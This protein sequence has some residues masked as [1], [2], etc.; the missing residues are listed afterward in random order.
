MEFSLPK[1]T[2]GAL[3]FFFGKS[4]PLD[5]CPIPAYL[6]EMWC[7]WWLEV[8]DLVSIWKYFNI[9]K[10]ENNFNLNIFKDAPP[11]CPPSIYRI[12]AECWNP[13]PEARPTFSIL[14]E[15][16]TACT[17][18]PEIMNSP[19]PSF[20]RPQSMERDATIMRPSGNDDFC[21]QVPNSSDYLIPLPDSRAIAE[22][23]LSEATCVTLP[24]T[25]TTHTLTNSHKLSD[26]CWETSFTKP[27]MKLMTAQQDSMEV[28]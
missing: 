4:F 3:A 28:Q 15:R 24:D 7:N 23:L 9:F 25:L 1:P 6:I 10:F 11:G 5:W 19:L 2:Y 21:L 18:D 8:V 14:L 16:L 12:M 22:R 17:Q 27:A 20:F 26:N 13:S